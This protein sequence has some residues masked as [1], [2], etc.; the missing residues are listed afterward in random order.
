MVVAAQSSQPIQPLEHALVLVKGQRIYLL[1]LPCVIRQHA[2]RH[3]DGLSQNSVSRS[4]P[5]HTHRASSW[6]ASSC[7]VLLRGR[8][9]VSRR[10]HRRDATRSVTDARPSRRRA[11]AIDVMR[12]DARPP[13]RREAIDATRRRR[14]R[15]EVVTGTTSRRRRSSTERKLK[16]TQRSTPRQHLL[17]L[18]PP[19]PCLPPD[20]ATN[21]ASTPPGCRNPRAYRRRF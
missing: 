13:P 14:H 9:P 7:G 18:L 15:A 19:P 8:R 17:H 16:I 21:A 6:L 11:R 4:C 10:S 1:S 2:V 20:V 12:R 3:F 5:P